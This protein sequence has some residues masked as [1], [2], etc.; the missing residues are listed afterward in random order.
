MTKFFFTSLKYPFW[1]YINFGTNVAFFFLLS[2]FFNLM[3]LLY[4]SCTDI[5]FLHRYVL[6]YFLYFQCLSQESGKSYASSVVNLRMVTFKSDKWNLFLFLH[7]TLSFVI[8]SILLKS[9]LYIYIYI[10]INEWWGERER[11]KRKI[12]SRNSAKMAHHSDFLL[13]QCT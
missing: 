11:K 13:E 12:K 7:K 5:F 4:L 1:K 9:S 2:F 8:V 3:L 6:T 10:Y